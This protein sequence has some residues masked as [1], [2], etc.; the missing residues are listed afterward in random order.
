MPRG[1][2]MNVDQHIFIAGY[3]ETKNIHLSFA[4]RSKDFSFMMDCSRPM[5]RAKFINSDLIR[6]ISQLFQNMLGGVTIN[7][8]S[9]TREMSSGFENET[10]CWK[11]IFLDELKSS[12]S[13]YATQTFFTNMTRL[14]L[15]CTVARSS[16]D[17]R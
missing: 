17:T 13:N 3:S 9:L 5:R 4:M 7:V 12:S 6:C 14:D 11:S 1:V 16:A 10:V 15:V 8:A 2:M